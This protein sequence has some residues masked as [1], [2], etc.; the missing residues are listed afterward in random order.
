MRYAFLF[1]WLVMPIGVWSAYVAWGTP[2]AIW[3]YQFRDNGD[4]NNPLAERWYVACTFVGWTGVV[5]V[6]AEAGHCPW[7][8]FFKAGGVQ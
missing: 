6:T 4:N 2:H 3:E 7:V 8:R 5:R 1:L